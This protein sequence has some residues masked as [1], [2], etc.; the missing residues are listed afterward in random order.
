MFVNAEGGGYANS[1]VVQKCGVNENIDEVNLLR[2]QR[3]LKMRKNSTKKSD[4]EV[5]KHV[6]NI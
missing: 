6:G 3:R 4:K 1:V 5:K 2:N